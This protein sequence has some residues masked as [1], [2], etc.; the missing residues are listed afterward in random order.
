MAS[1]MK[2]ELP[3]L[4]GSNRNYSERLTRE[5]SSLE[6]RLAKLKH[7]QETML[8]NPEFKDFINAM[9]EVGYL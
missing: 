4:I 9:S 2:C 5:I 1:E 7:M 8:K 3:A 6:E